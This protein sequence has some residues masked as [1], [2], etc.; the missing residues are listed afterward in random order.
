MIAVYRMDTGVYCIGRPLVDFPQDVEPLL[1]AVDSGPLQMLI[2]Q[3][4]W[5]GQEGVS[6]GVRRH[7]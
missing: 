6:S 3:R 7:G 5:E 4:G 2:S 1:T